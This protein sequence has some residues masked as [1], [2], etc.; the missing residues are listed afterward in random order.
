[1]IKDSDNNLDSTGETNNSNETGLHLSDESIN[2]KKESG[3]PDSEENLSEKNEAGENDKEKPKKKHFIR[4]KWL[5]VVLR[6]ILCII[7]FILLIPVLLYVPPV[8]TFLKN[9]ACDIVYDS[10]GMKI[11]IDSF[12]LRWPLDVELDNVLVIDANKDT[13]VNARQVIADV[14][15]QPL[16]DLDVKLNRLKLVDGDYRMISPDSSMILRVHAGLLDVDSKS[17]ANIRTSEILLN[18]A[19]LKDGDL[20]LYMNVWKQKPTPPDSTAST[21]FIIKANDLH[22]ENFTFGMSMLPTIDTLRLA[23]NDLRLKGGVIDLGENSVKW[24]LASVN[25][26]EATYLT[27]TP[28]WVAQHPA[29][30]PLPSTGPPMRIM[31]DSI[32][33]SDFK[34]LYATKGA[35]P[36]A[37]FDPSYIQVSDV[38]IGMKDFYNESS[39]VRLPITRLEAK[40]RSGLRIL[41]GSGT[42][43]VDSIGLTLDNLAVKTLYSTLRATADVPFAMMEL[44]PDAQTSVT[45]QASIGLPDVDAFMPALKAY[46]SKIPARNPLEF[47]LKAEGSLSDVEISR[48]D[49][50]LRE[51][52]EIKA[53][54]YAKNP[55]DIKK[56]KAFL[57]FDGSLS[58]PALI[59]KFVGTGGI[60][61]P[62]FTI[63][64]TASADRDTY[65]ADF[66][67]LSSAGDV[68]AD[69]RVSLNAE[70]Y[71]V[72]AT[73][74]R[75]NVAQFAP[76][77][78]IGK[79]SGHIKADG[80][81]FNPVNGKAT[82]NANLLISAIEYN[83][84]LFNDI[85]ADIA[86]RPDGNFDLTASSPNAGLDFDITGSGSVHPDNYTFDISAD[87]RDL[88]LRQIGLTDSVN[89]GYGTIYLTGTAS[90]EKWL[91]DARLDLS[92]FK[93][94]IP[95]QTIAIPGEAYAEI[96]ATHDNTEIHID[97]DLTYLDFESA[98]G[99][100]NIIDRFT[101][102]SDIV[103][104]Q[105]EQRNLAVDSISNLLPPFNLTMRASGK[106]L[107]NQFL[108]TYEMSLDTLHAQITHDSLLKGDIGA[109]R[110]K[111]ESISLDTLTLSLNQ[112]RNL[113]DYK[114][115]LGNRPGTL[116]EFAK[117]NLNGYLGQ[118][119]LAASLSQQ[120]IK[121]ETG[122]RI[123]LTAAMMDS[124][125]SIHFTPLKSTIAYMPWTFNNDNF[126]DC[127]I[128]NRRIDANLIASSAESSIMLRTE[129][130]PDGAKEL[131]AKIDNLKIQDFLNMAIDAPPVTGALNTDLRVKYDN[132][133]FTGNGTIDLTNLYYAKT[134]IGDFNLDLAALY[135][136]SGNTDVTAALKI[137]GQRAMEAYASLRPDSI[138]AMTPDSLG[139]RLTRFPISVANPFLDNMAVLGGHL[140]GH[141]RMDGSFT[142]PQLNGF[143]AFDSV[144]AKIPMAGSTLRFDNDSVKVRTN[145]V[146]FDKFAVY[147][148]NS[149]PLTLDGTV[150]ARS[151]SQIGFDLSLDGKNF[152]PIGNDS[153]AKSDIYGKLFLDL[154]A[155][156]KGNMNRMDINANLDVLG[157][158]DVTYVVTSSATQFT[159][160]TDNDVVKFV[161][162]NDTTQ[163]A[164]ADSIS[165]MMN[166]RINA[167]VVVSPGTQVTVLLP[168]LLTGGSN[169]TDRVELQP[170]A[171]LTYFQNYMGDM[172]LNGNIILGQGFAKYSIPVVGQKN[173]V[174]N[175]ASRITWSGDVMNPSFNISATD[176]MKA[177]VTSGSN[178]RLVNFLVTL[179]ATGNLNNPKVAFDLSTNDDISIQNELQSM[180]PDQRQTQ[181]MNLLLYGQ[182]ISGDTKGNANLGGNMLYSFLES[183]LNSWAAKN[184]RGVDLSFGIDQ[185][186]KMENGAS[187]TETSYSY[188]VSKSLF[189]NRFKIQVGGNYST[190]ASADENLEQ[191]LISDISLEYIL[192]QT[193]TTNMAVRLFRHT[194][195][196]SILEGEITE[197]GAGFV[198]KR[199]LDNLKRL[200]RFLLPRKKRKKLNDAEKD[201]TKVDSTAIKP[202]NEDD[203]TK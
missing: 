39:T 93:W 137:D 105:V 114:I 20:K 40:E 35:K 188:Q 17:S 150:D 75:V 157:T 11:S 41:D 134:R 156:V 129:P 131:H 79:V 37:G 62:T 164:E 91:Y 88:D 32:S 166:M 47:D 177:N 149:N 158:S 3:D 96:V 183:Q 63:K 160:T 82:T 8:Q 1:M 179:Q 193:Q 138:G 148:Q 112:R 15:L 4:P 151:F 147:G 13:M 170:T 59:G 180:S 12:R 174:F 161:N 100:K 76:D 143:I 187:S 203:S 199:K 53:K 120:N 67:L 106:G 95:G 97:S 173:F 196:E 154:G 49:A 178:S 18:K 104:K 23:V 34:A 144:T 46:T 190:D 90:P 68:A 74:S 123:G 121:G 186:D 45:A 55:M 44:K 73:L 181:A 153:R 71:N 125:V 176:E 43:G 81:G 22:L 201:T 168:A 159:S 169:A 61:I 194:G 109:T 130:L 127:N 197:T 25:G 38:V 31:G 42:V 165:S 124:T 126:I 198:M 80:A 57:D 77:L 128:F 113:L 33:L 202:K 163:V 141:M 56:L 122:Y 6:V 54:G 2:S 171:D 19:Y 52:L 84:R 182:Y 65:G 78:G 132:R 83:K 192:R 72:D 119:R 92:D 7:I 69:G 98:E 87:I 140:N 24:N 110:F 10:T 117:V 185:Y 9:V 107:L 66:K 118:N 99:L 21:P 86:L 70:R 189:N 155:T 16:L 146:S 29:P 85:R 139:V 60:K 115:H 162:F 111:S 184:I 116:D 27:P 145:I 108:S 191:N 50:S 172:R 64:G 167:K 30:P 152:Q 94:N 200:F 36:A 14:K 26:G 102:V 89:N 175:P 28:E 195:Y 142:K 133:K 136:L 58:N 101:N 5:R 135:A 48:F 51:V 103:M